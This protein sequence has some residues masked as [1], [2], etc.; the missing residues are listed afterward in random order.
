[1]FTSWPNLVQNGTYMEEFS[2][3]AGSSETTAPTALV[4]FNDQDSMFGNLINIKY[5]I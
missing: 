3:P 4:L 1:M 5:Y 2:K